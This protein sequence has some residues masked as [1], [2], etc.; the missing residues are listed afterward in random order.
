MI[1]MALSQYMK[2]K[3]M[4]KHSTKTCQFLPKTV[5]SRK[6]QNTALTLFFLMTKA[7]IHMPQLAF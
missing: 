5:L 6:E 4:K 2:A 1:K 7:A 3:L